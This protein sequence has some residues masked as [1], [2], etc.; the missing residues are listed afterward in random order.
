M[1]LIL[2]GFMGSGKTTIGKKLAKK[3]N[4]KFIDTDAV[5]E[6]KMK[7]PIKKIFL[8][9]GEFFFRRLERRI[10]LNINLKESFILSTGGGM[11][12]FKNN[13]NIMKNK[14]IVVYLKTPKNR[15]F[16]VDKSNR[17]LFKKA[18]IL[19]NKRKYCYQKADFTIENEKIDK[20][21][22]KLIKLVR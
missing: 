2:T 7:M 14:G 9:Y 5:I 11:P 22:K 18:K 21:L 15:L 6:R 19:L 10:L 13:I 1:N 4:Y 8:L 16:K 20:T 17:P 3:I 12:C